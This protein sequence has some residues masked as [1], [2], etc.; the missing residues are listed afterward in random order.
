MLV[1]NVH[2]KQDSK[3]SHKRSVFRAFKKFYI[4]ELYIRDV[5]ASEYQEREKD[6][7]VTDIKNIAEKMSVSYTLKK[8]INLLPEKDVQEIAKRILLCFKS[9]SYYKRSR[10]RNLNSSN[11]V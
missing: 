1:T 3:L 8:V 10:G 7:K 5:D 4:T 9:R 6:S 2:K 11:I